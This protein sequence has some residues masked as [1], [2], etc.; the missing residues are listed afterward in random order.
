MLPV[1]NGREEHGKAADHLQCP[2]IANVISHRSQNDATQ[3]E[4]HVVQNPNRRPM[5][6]SRRFNTFMNQLSLLLLLA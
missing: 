1:E 3:A 2:P 6:P 4:E 5:F